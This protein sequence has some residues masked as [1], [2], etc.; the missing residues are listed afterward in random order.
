MKLLFRQPV[1]FEL[2]IVIH[3]RHIKWVSHHKNIDGLRTGAPATTS[4][5]KKS[6][7]ICKNLNNKNISLVWVILWSYTDACKAITLTYD[8]IKIR[9]S[10]ASWICTRS[11]DLIFTM[12]VGAAVLL[13]AVLRTPQI[14]KQLWHTELNHLT[15]PIYAQ[16]LGL[17]YTFAH[18]VGS[19]LILLPTRLFP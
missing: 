7:N 11:T 2:L 9:L 3:I 13:C 6:S 1:K 14:W 18:A 10:K 15:L 19:D 4:P 5:Q 16:P 17:W 12:C 8:I